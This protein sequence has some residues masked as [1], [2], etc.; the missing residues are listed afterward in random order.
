[1]ALEDELKGIRVTLEGILAELKAGKTVNGNGHNKIEAA[2]AP[3]AVAT[4]APAPAAPAPVMSAGGGM[5]KIGS[6]LGSADEP[7]T[8]PSTNR[9][10]PGF[11]AAQFARHAKTNFARLQEAAGEMLPRA[12]LA[13]SDAAMK[14]KMRQRYRLTIQRYCES[15]S[16]ASSTS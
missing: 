6:A 5:P 12:L 7:V 16:F 15:G 14:P 4:A 1:M 11:D 3:V 10:P 8:V 9:F 13:M 2:P